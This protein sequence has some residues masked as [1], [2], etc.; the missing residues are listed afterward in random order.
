MLLAR[1]RR[2]PSPRRARAADARHARRRDRR[3]AGGTPPRVPARLRRGGDLPAARAGDGGRARRGRQGRRRPAAAGRGAARASA[4]RSRTACSRSCR[5]WASPTSRRTAA[6][7]SS[8]SSGS[9]RRWSTSCFAGTPSPVGG[10]GF[11]EL[12]DETLRAGG[13]DPPREPGYV[14]FRKGGEPHETDPDVR[15]GAAHALRAGRPERA[16]E[17]GTSASRSSST[18]ATADGA[19]RPARARSGGRAGA[20]WT[21]SSRRTRSSSASPP[22]GCRTARSRPR[23]T[24]RSRSR[25]TGCAPARTAAR[26]GR[27]R[28]ASAPSATRGSS[29]SPPGRF[30]VT[31]EYAAFA[32]ELQIKIAQGSKPGEGGQLPGHKVSVEI[33]RLRHTH[34]GRRADLAAAAP[35]H[36]LDRG[37]RAADLRPAP[38]Q[39]RRP[40]I[41]VKLVAESGVGLVA[42]GVVKALADV[43][44]IAGS[45]RRHRRQPARRRSSTPGCPGSSASPRRSARWSRTA[46]AG[47]SGCVPTAA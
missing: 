40:T 27:T 7:R 18:D 29:R 42:A 38:G 26:A 24:R 22:A 11:A 1:R 14:K 35:R 34:A 45:R 2:P 13:V 9:P 44:H 21:R 41:S 5:R 32:D 15:R 20:R 3:G 6:P 17:T 31:P 28:R 25:S 46:C 30:G 36:L 33:A 8:T 39:S 23:R 16:C 19:S 37:P 12:E 43:V 47:G 10:I 4:R